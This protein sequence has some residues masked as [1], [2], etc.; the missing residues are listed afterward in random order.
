MTPTILPISKPAACDEPIVVSGLGM[1]TALGRDRETSWRGMR[2]GKCG[3]GWVRS[4]PGLPDDEWFGAQVDLPSE[5]D[6]SELKAIRLARIAAREA[7]TDAAI[8]WHQVDASR[9][10]CAIAGH[11]GDIRGVATIVDALGPDAPRFSDS[12]RHPWWSQI[13]PS[14]ACDTLAHEFQLG[15]PRISHSTAC[16]SGLISLLQA[17]R[18]IRDGQCEIALAGGGE[19]INALFAAG[20][21]TM[22]A[23]AEGDDPREACLPFDQR[24]KGFVMGEGGAMFVVERLSHALKRGA[25]IYCTI[26]PGV[27]LSE[28]HHLT[29][30]DVQSE[31][32]EHLIEG[33]LQQTALQP[34]DVQY[35]N[36]HGTGTLQNDAAEI[37][38]ISSVFASCLDQIQVSATKS[39]I[40]HLVKA[41]GC[42][43]LA[44]TILGLRDGIAPP[45]LGLQQLD[46]SCHFNCVPGTAAERRYQHALKLSLAFGGHLVG[47]IVSRWNQAGSSYAYPS[48]RAA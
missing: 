13:L 1:I 38:G 32:L 16:A 18:A 46:P 28:A 11:M 23:L 3:I 26:A 5:G 10:G 30:L 21:R 4:V 44:V 42:V 17:V 8:D 6:D 35:I 47:T 37:A 2:A 33:A 12:D 29:G 7:L 9:M 27:M 48:R 19:A 14:T 25:R 45:T 31:T 34:S 22:R 15:G 40:G 20:F 41:A 39:M 43:E 24:R 36:A